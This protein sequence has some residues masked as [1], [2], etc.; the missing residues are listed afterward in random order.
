MVVVMSQPACAIG[1][2]SAAGNFEVELRELLCAG[3]HARRL[4]AHV[5]STNWLLKEVTYMF[6]VR[7]MF[8]FNTVAVLSLLAWII[9]ITSTKQPPKRWV[10]WIGVS[11]MVTDLVVNFFG[12]R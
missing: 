9:Y 12:K 5:F 6:W 1:L 10:H 11:I 4:R 2:L 3:R 7:P 8:W